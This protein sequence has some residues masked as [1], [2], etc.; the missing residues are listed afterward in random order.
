MTIETLP[1]PINSTTYYK[2]VQVQDATFTALLNTE[3]PVNLIRVDRI[4]LTDI[5]CVHARGAI[6]GSRIQAKSV[7]LLLY[8]QHAFIKIK[9]FFLQ[10]QDTLSTFDSNKIV[11]LE[12]MYQSKR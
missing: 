1:L 8:L 7:V 4:L 11:Q 6:S 5:C 3:C 12:Y 10:K 9:I 2:N